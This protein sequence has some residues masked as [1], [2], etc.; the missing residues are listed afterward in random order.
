MLTILI[1][2]KSFK[3]ILHVVDIRASQ[4]RHHPLIMAKAYAYLTGSI[5]HV[6]R[7]KL[8]Q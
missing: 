8:L 1:S 3:E 6:K 7:K 2:E 4:W 5:H